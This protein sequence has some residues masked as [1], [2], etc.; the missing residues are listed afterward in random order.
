LVD[1]STVKAQ[2][3]EKNCGGGILKRFFFRKSQRLLSNNDFKAVLSRNCCVSNDLVKLYVAENAL[4]SPR[5][6]ISVSK[7]CGSA[8]VRNRLKRLAREVFRLEQ[9]NIP[10]G[11]DYLLIFSLKMS[12]KAT[13]GGKSAGRAVT[14]EEVRRSLV[15]LVGRG[16]ARCDKK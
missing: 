9:H 1:I 4:G 5:L 3:I 2:I 16:V 8:V 15:D 13:S 6:G 11:Y 10:A 7:A 12:K 14:F